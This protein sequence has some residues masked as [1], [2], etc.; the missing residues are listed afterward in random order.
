MNIFKSL[1]LSFLYVVSFKCFN[2]VSI[3]FVQT[4]FNAEELRLLNFYSK[5]KKKNTDNRFFHRSTGLLLCFSH[6]NMISLSRQSIPSSYGPLRRRHISLVRHIQFPRTRHPPVRTFLR[7]HRP[8][9]LLNLLGRN[10]YHPG[11]VQ[12]TPSIRGS[13]THRPVY[14]CGRRQLELGPALGNQVTHHPR[15]IFQILEKEKQQKL[16]SNRCNAKNHYFMKMVAFLREGGRRGHS[17][18]TKKKDGGKF[19][20]NS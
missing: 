1:F 11:R 13:M 2:F 8:W 20:K 17:K 10:L 18:K 12:R 4:R 3:F 5:I 14:I 9:D 7:A 6:V 15:T 19:E 16:T